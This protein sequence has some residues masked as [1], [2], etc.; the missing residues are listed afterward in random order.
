VADI[1][2]RHPRTQ[3]LVYAE[4]LNQWKDAMEVQEIK[5]LL[6]SEEKPSIIPNPLPTGQAAKDTV[7]QEYH[8]S[9][10]GEQKGKMSA[11]AIAHEV[12][13]NRTAKHRV[14]FTAAKCTTKNDYNLRFLTM[15]PSFG[16]LRLGSLTKTVAMKD[17]SSR[18]F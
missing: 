8:Y 7:V 16:P 11:E 17:H 13:N 4:R 6:S 14:C 18:L 1:V 10:N 9:C 3:H 15:G 5:D 12:W 2:K